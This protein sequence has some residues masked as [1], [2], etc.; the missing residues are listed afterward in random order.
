MKG[1]A[2]NP[3]LNISWDFVK[4]A[5]GH[6]MRKEYY[7]ITDIATIT[8]LST[9]TI[10]NY[11]KNGFINGSKKDGAWIFD[12]NEV[13]KL[14]NE[15][16]VSQSIQIKSDS[17]VKDFIN[18]KKKSV[19]SVC[20]IFDYVVNNFEEAEIL[21]DKIIE[22]I[23]SKQYGKINFSFKYDHKINVVRIIISGETKQILQMMQDCLN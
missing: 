12:E 5:Y 16:F 3:C 20:S 11:I 7:S 1:Y 23:D 4:S 18:V 10:R 14:L 8:G 21:C 2:L 17:I 19:N 6:K 15:P 22:N 9:R 13:G